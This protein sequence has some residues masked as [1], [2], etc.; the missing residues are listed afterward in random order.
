MISLTKTAGYEAALSVVEN[1]VETEIYDIS[2]QTALVEL[3]TLFGADQLPPEGLFYTAKEVALSVLHD[4]FDPD[5]DLEIKLQDTPLA[6]I[7]NDHGL[8]ICKHFAS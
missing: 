1:A 2:T 6:T 7:L 8:R 3:L 4:P 5:N